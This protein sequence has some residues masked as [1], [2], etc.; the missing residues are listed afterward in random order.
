MKVGAFFYVK[1]E[2]I[3]LKKSIFKKGMSAFLAVLMCFS[4]MVGMGTTTALAAEAGETDTVVMMSFP[5]EGD[6]NYSGNWGHPELH[7]MNGW[8]AG[9]SS[10]ITAYTVGS[11][12]GTACYCI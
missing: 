10:K 7:Y 12:N 5:R 8:S 9:S 2:E 3:T 6:A 11:W 1:K 4:A